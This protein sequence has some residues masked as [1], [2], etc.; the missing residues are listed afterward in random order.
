MLAQPA[1]KTSLPVF[2]ISIGEAHLEQVDHFPYLGGILSSNCTAEK[3]VDHRIGAAYSAF[4]K[5]YKRVFKKKDLNRT[6][7]LMVYQAV[8]ISTLLYGCEAWALFQ[9]DLQKLEQLHQRKL[10][11]ILNIKWDDY[12]VS[13]ESMI[14]K[15]RLRWSGHVARMSDA[16][17]PRQLLCSELTLGYVQGDALSSA[18]KISSKLLSRKLELIR[19]H[20]R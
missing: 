8:V 1:P 19:G 6:S 13:V 12:A 15:H 14:V 18:T 7:K 16:R 9:K 2:N 3:D 10:R 5:L 4:G 11:S 20:G 17:L